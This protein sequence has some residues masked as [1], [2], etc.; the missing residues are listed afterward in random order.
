MIP[1]ITPAIH[2]ATHAHHAVHVDHAIHPVVHHVE[3]VIHAATIPAAIPV[4]YRNGA[5]GLRVELL[6]ISF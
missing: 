3:H 5:Y 6:L 4:H 1:V 2:V